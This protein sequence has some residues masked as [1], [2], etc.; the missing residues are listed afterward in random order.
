MS[1]DVATLCATAFAAMDALQRRVAELEA[2]EIARL[3]APAV[4]EALVEA[5][6]E[7]FNGAASWQEYYEHEREYHRKH[8]RAV[9]AVVVPAVRE[10]CAVACERMDKDIVCPEECAAA[11]R[12]LGEAG[13]A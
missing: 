6:C 4:G 9:L 1:D 7:T 3:S 12:A 10:E 13:N 5:A 11:I 8:M 2:A